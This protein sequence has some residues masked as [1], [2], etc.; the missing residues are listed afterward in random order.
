MGSQRSATLYGYVWGFI[1]TEM[2][3]KNISISWI[4]SSKE[5]RLIDFTRT[6]HGLVVLSYD[7]EL[8]FS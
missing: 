4:I 5:A 2:F 6:K 7:A 1:Y 3:Y 8:I